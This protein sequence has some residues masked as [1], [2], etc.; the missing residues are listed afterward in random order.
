MSDAP[1]LRRT[2]K[3]MSAARTDELLRQGYAGR[4]ATIGT[5]G[6]PYNVPLLHVQ[7]DGEIWVHNTSAK[8]H[9][10]ANVEH[11]DR[12]C[13]E[14]DEPGKVFNYGRFECDTGLAFCSVI[15]FGRIRIVDDKAQETAFFEAFMNK[16]SDRQSDRQRGFFP[17]LDQVTV[18]A[19]AVERLS[20]KETPL[21]APD[22]RWP[23]V[24][25]TKS[26]HAKP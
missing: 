21:P 9:L 1:Q 4:L 22:A 16:Y 26:P 11:D 19:I 2:D 25:L 14:I 13:F 12:V 23:A 7:I 5:D 17:R 10:R 15:I 24:D 8:G 6:W 18:Y 3:L 20:G